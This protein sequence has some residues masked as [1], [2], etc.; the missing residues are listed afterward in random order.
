M[1]GRR[2]SRI[3]YGKDSWVL[4]GTH[5]RAYIGRRMEG[6]SAT[7]AELLAFERD[8]GDTPRPAR[9]RA[10]RARLGLS[11]LT[12][13]ALLMRAINAAAAVEL[14]AELVHELRVKRDAGR[15]RRAWRPREEEVPA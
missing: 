3:F 11:E 4:A 8:H 1:R 6:R 10:I 15:S 12:Y 9:A 7:I 13:S 14:D 5:L 2:I